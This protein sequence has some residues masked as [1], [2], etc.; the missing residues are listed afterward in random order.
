MTLKELLNTCLNGAQ[1]EVIVEKPLIVKVEN[2]CWLKAVD[3][4]SAFNNFSQ[5]THFF[6]STIKF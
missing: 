6:G 3:R 4:G 2:S 1:S 5:V